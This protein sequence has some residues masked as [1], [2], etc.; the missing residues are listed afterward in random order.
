MNGVVFRNVG[1]DGVRYAGDDGGDLLLD[2][3][4]VGSDR[5]LVVLEWDPQELVLELERLG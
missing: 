1:I 4:V 5:L 2:G 3:A